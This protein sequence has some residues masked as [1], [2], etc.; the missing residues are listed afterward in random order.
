MSVEKVILVGP[1]GFCA[2]VD[3]AI[4]I[5]E[6]AIEIY[7][8]PMYVKPEIVHNKTV[9]DDL[10]KKGAVFVE[11]VS[12]IPE[13]SY[14]I[15]SA[16]GIA[17]KVREDAKARSLK[18]IDATC[19]L[20]TKI[21]LEVGRYSKEGKEIIYIGHKGHPEAVGVTGIMP[22][23][24]HL[25][26]SVEDVARLHVKDP[27]RLVYLTQTTLSVDETKEII[28]ALKARFPR[29]E[30]PPAEDICYAT[31]NRQVAIKKLAPQVDLILVVG[32]KN[33]SNSNRLVETAR[34]AGCQAH[35]IDNASEI[36]PAWLESVQ[37]VGVSAGASAPEH[38]VQ[39]IAAHFREQGAIVEELSLIQE[40]MKFV[41]P[42]EVKQSTVA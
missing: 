12:E 27:E 11:E 40:N 35:L 14:C 37:R 41:L 13:G 23:T 8:K 30:A 3:R 42:K 9:C 19:P 15:F 1:R 10:R 26:E 29:I 5:V 6:K 20:V 16:H 33:S 17:P 21:H 39:E 38:L 18:A 28:K 2:G 36:Q 24:T 34:T 31:T 32:S 7:G 25:V 4:E 22:G